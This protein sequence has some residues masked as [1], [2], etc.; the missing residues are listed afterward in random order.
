MRRPLSSQSLNSSATT[1][2]SGA[3]NLDLLLQQT[4]EPA[5]LQHAPVREGGLPNP[6]ERR[7]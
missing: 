5:P 1:I 4:L 7:I 2:V 3:T 6:V